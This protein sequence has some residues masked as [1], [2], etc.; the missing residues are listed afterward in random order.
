MMRKIFVVQ[1]Q[2]G[3]GGGLHAVPSAIVV[4]MASLFECK[5]TLTRDKRSV[6][7]K[8]TMGVMEVMMLALSRGTSVELSCD[9]IDEN[10]AFSAI[11]ELLEA[12]DP[13]EMS[14]AFRKHSREKNYNGTDGN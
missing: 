13:D 3:R 10:E 7:A 11:G 5:I 1:N 8:S 4:S 14:A 12:A 6:N 9:G 2:D